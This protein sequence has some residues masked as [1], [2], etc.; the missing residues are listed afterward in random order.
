M[1]DKFHKDLSDVTVTFKDGEV[2]VYRITAGPS[3]G[4]YFA[5]EAKATGILTLWN[6]QKSTSIPVENI[7]DWTLE[8]V[9]AEDAKGGA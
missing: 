1:G 7:R 2:K 8:A 9:P 3:I 5:R 4:G 6:A